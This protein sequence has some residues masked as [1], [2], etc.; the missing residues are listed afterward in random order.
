MSVAF[1]WLKPPRPD[2]A[3]PR[4]QLEHHIQE[5]MS[6]V[7]TCVLSTISKD[8]KPVASPI[9][10]YADGLDIYMLPDEGSPKLLAMQRDPHVSLAVHKSH[11]SWASA[12]GVQYFGKA[13]I[14]EP[15]TPGWQHGMNIFRWRV[16]AEELE[17]DLNEPPKLALVKVVPDRILYTDTWLWPLGYGARQKWRREP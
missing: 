4:D 5:M 8:G 7:N 15:D 11:N 12:R 6:M 3:L 10:Y 13:T 16:W 1:P 2:K 17:W 9:E 14:L